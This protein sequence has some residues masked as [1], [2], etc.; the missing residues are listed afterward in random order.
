MAD[1]IAEFT[2]KED[3]PTEA[4]ENQAS[5]WTVH[6]DGSSTKNAR[7]VGIIIRSPECNI[8]KRAIR[9]QYTTT[10]NEAEYEALLV[11]LKTAKT[12]GA[13]ELDVHSDS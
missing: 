13:T 11:E 2:N 6:I 7:G 1:F 5:R 9:L 12:L 10:N 4:E 3:E 8:I